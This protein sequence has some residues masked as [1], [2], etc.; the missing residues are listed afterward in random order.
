VKESRRYAASHHCQPGS[1][2][3]KEKNMKKI[4]VVILPSKVNNVKDAL[5]KIGTNKMTV[6]KVQGFG[7]R[8]YCRGGKYESKYEPAFFGKTKIEIEVAEEDLEK[9]LGSIQASIEGT[10]Y[11]DEKV[12]VYSLDDTVKPEKNVRS[13]AAV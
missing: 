9:V 6:S 5:R 11:G 10:A 1:N 12:V 4:E 3:F 8:G 7:D 13:V 2:V